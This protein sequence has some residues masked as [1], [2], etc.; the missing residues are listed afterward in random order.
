MFCGLLKHFW[1]TA[2]TVLAL[3]ACGGN[4]RVLMSNGTK[5]KCPG[6]PSCP[7][8]EP[9]D[10]NDDPK[11]SASADQIALMLT[12]E[13]ADGYVNREESAGSSPLVAPEESISGESLRYTDPLPGDDSLTCDAQQN[14]QHMSAPL[15]S[16]LPDEGSYVICG[17]YPGIDNKPVYVRSSVILMDITRPRITAIGR[18]QQAADGVIN[19]TERFMTSSLWTVTTDEVTTLA[20]TTPTQTDP[21]CDETQSYAASSSRPSDLPATDG[22]YVVCVKASDAAGNA[23]YKKSPE[24]T[25][26][27]TPPQL[28]SLTLGGAAGDS[29]IN[30]SEGDLLAS[31]LALAANGQSGVSYSAPLPEPSITCNASVTYAQTIPP[32]VQ[33]ITTDGAYVVCVR[34]ED[35][36]GNHTFGKSPTVVRDTVPP[37]NLSLGGL[38]AVFS[39]VGSINITVSGT[40]VVAYRIHGRTGDIINGSCM[41]STSYT[42]GAAVSV[43]TP[44]TTF[45]GLAGDSSKSLCVMGLDEAGNKTTPVIHNW[46]VNTAPPPA[47]RDI[48]AVSDGTGLT[49]QWSAISANYPDAVY[50]IVRGLVDAT[51]APANSMTYTAGN[52]SAGQDIVYVGTGTNFYDT[53]TPGFYYE[54]KFY[55]VDSIGLY[56]SPARSLRVVHAAPY[57]PNQTGLDAPPAVIAE[58]AGSTFGGSADISEDGLT[59]VLGAAKHNTGEGTVDAKAGTGA[60]FVYTR[61]T[62]SDPWTFDAKL[63]A[64]GVNGRQSDDGFGGHVAISGATIV[65]AATGHDYDANGENFLDYAGAVY[66]FVKTAGTWNLQQKITPSGTNARRSMDIFGSDVDIMGDTLVVGANGHEFD[67]NGINEASSS[68][69]VFVFTRST[70]TWT[71]TQKL[72]PNETANIRQSSQF[73]TSVALSAS[74]LLAVGAPY[75]SYDEAGGNQVYQSGAVYIFQNTGTWT[76]QKKLIATGTNARNSGDRFGATL[77]FDGATLAIGATFHGFDVNGDANTLSTGAVYIYTVSGSTWTPQQKLV[78]FGFGS[79][80]GQSLAL[81]GNSLAVGTTDTNF[82]GAVYTYTRSGS[83]WSDGQK[84]IAT[85]TNARQ[86]YDWFASSLA[87]KGNSLI[88]GAPYHDWDAAGTA[89]AK[90]MGAAFSFQ[91]DG[92]NWSLAN[93]ITNTA[94]RSI[95]RSSLDFGSVVAVSPDGLSLF[96]GAPEDYI[97]G[98]GN[99]AVDDVIGSVFYYTRANTSDPWSFQQRLVPPVAKLPFNDAYFGRSLAFD[100]DTLVV[101]ASSDGFDENGGSHIWASGAAYVFVKNGANYDLQ[102]KLSRTGANARSFYDYFGSAVAI[103]GDKIA[104]GAYNHA[105]D[106][107]GS[108][109]PNYTGK[110]AVWTYERSGGV[111]TQTQKIADHTTNGR[112]GDFGKALQLTPS[113]LFVGAVHANPNMNSTTSEAGSVQ[114]YG[115]NAGTWTHKQEIYEPSGPVTDHHFGSSLSVFGTTLMVGATDSKGDENGGNT[116]YGAGAVYVFE[117]E[118][119]TWNFKQKLVDVGINGRSE[120]SR[121]GSA[122]KVVGNTAI[123]SAAYNDYDVTGQNFKNWAG[124]ITTF[125]RSGSKWYFGQKHTATGLNSWDSYDTFGASVDFAGTQIYI[126]SPGHDYDVTTG[127]IPALDKGSV[128]ILSPP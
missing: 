42:Y 103:A 115:Y 26:D 126:G 7:T 125:H 11:P 24:V 36:A 30:S 79:Y 3:S 60:V 2:A 51:W 45:S 52:Q 97:D 39:R 112:R 110:G 63:Q 15:T 59:L 4:M 43:A 111:W 81:D 105:F 37:T 76:Q 88:A 31:F 5:E 1:L 85:G 67:A 91:F 49:L 16:S 62:T 57:Y 87:M 104:V 124:S 70:G 95:S 101:G 18:T 72:V 118:T 9:S 123:V 14:Y 127:Q 102:Q 64:S 120:Y 66:V 19:L 86:D 56:S 94:T 10:S 21:K 8:A 35:E 99:P 98:N 74:G 82:Y 55:T 73:G 100:N 58:A 53:A 121:F 54:Y 69:A 75:Q 32:S 61:P 80:V 68:G 128:F 40:D 47:P 122:I 25:L 83:V 50:L 78:A 65:V 92:S 33:D 46:T 44:I 29:Y 23:A 77:A 90:N 71:L 93:K 114:I 38:P 48:S 89:F 12:G 106:A 28:T 34:L 113:T 22:G 13:A 6:D 107:T 108:G 17:S 84:V 20:Y 96:V 116:I 109:D 27:T 41:E 117:E 119:G